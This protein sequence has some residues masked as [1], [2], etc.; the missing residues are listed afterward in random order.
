M[1][2]SNVSGSGSLSGL[3]TPGVGSGLDV[4]TIVGKLM[5]VEQQPITLLNQQEASYQA[6][7][8]AYGSMKGAV[9]SFQTA[10][11]NLSTAS[12]FQAMSSSSSD[13]TV[14]TASATTDATPGSF[15]LSVDHLA[16]SQ[17][18]AASG[19]ADQ[20]AASST[21]TLVI[22]VGTGAAKTITLDSTN[23]TLTGLRDAINAAAAGVSATIV[24]GGGTT[25]YKLVLTADSTGA[26]NTINVTNNLGAG[27]LHDA[28]AS[29]G[30]VRAAKDAALTVNGVAISSAGNNLN[31]AIPGINVNLLKAGDST[32]TIA[33]DTSAIQ[34][35]V[36][37]FVKSYNDLN[38]TLTNLTAYNASTKQGGPL[39]GDSAAQKLQ[40]DVR[41]IVG[42]TVSNS[43]GALTTLSQVG[44]SFQKDGSLTLDSAKLS[45]AVANNFSDVA[46]LFA[47]QGRSSSALLTYNGSSSNTQT[48]SYQ[49]NI[50]AAGTQA[51]LTATTAAA[52]S[53]D[54]TSSNDTFALMVNGVASGPLTLAH[55]TGYTQ[56]QL[57]QATQSAINGSA[58]LAAAGITVAVGVNAGKLV[59]TS[60]NY[61]STSS[62][63]GATGA[64]LSA[65]GLSGSE[66]ANGTDVAGSF[67]VNGKSVAATGAGQSLT[68][69]TGSPAEGLSLRYTGSPAQ[70]LATPTITLNL[71]Q[72]IAS[73]LQ[74][75]A[76]NI[77]DSNGT[78]SART[79]GI[80]S[81]IKD[82]GTRRDAITRRLT[83]TEASYRAQFNALDTLISQLNQTSSFLT[84]QLASLTSSTK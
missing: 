17:V 62:I 10:M 31:A 68:G 52:V 34:G 9:S 76:S 19:I 3:A 30:E 50:T 2:V 28:V 26:A 84:Q 14:L 25:P 5:A 80:N 75:L 74:Q 51:S 37:Q 56:S 23:N 59:I 21:G 83:Q 7:L 79:D 61:G 41:A 65:L 29:L 39:L 69:P 70:A 63:S 36:G 48:G 8:S 22:Q 6:K 72:G 60:S 78:I 43:G 18:L 58:A 71:S 38:S 35:A 16:Q 27:T 1:A 67:L 42:G 20:S 64:A 81:S 77:L 13:S 4:N 11:Q 12:K 15:D 57:A 44:V 66:A 82:I 55:G 45:T 54:I 47:I 46:S 49:V 40:S 73:K 33:R 53:T 32:I 24:N